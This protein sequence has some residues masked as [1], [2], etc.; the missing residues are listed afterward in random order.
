MPKNKSP[1]F[2]GDAIKALS[3]ADPVMRKLIRTYKGEILETRDDAYRTLLRAIV[4]QQISTKAADA[5]WA[6][7][8]TGVKKICVKNCLPVTFEQYR[9]FGF[10]GQKAAYV[11][12]LT[13]FFHERKHLERDWAKMTDEE[14]IADITQIKGIGRWTAEMFLIFHLKRPDV[15]PLGD[16]GLVNAI[17]K[18]YNHGERLKPKEMT[19][20]AEMWRPYR[21]VATWYLWRTYD[22]VAV[23]Y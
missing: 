8:E 22:T 13:R 14:V 23:A 19:A 15:L 7:F 12:D 5:I 18:H 3:K 6:R 10:S 11:A 9:G 20:L 21:S 17:A 2:W 1:E 16:L 4:G